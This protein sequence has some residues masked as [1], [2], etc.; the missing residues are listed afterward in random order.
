VVGTRSQLSR[1]RQ[2]VA[3]SPQI[4]QGAQW[5][6][7]PK[8]IAHCQFW[9][10]R[11]PAQCSSG[12]HTEERRFTGTSDSVEPRSGPRPDRGEPGARI[13]MYVISLRTRPARAGVQDG[14]NRPSLCP[15]RK[16]HR[17]AQIHAH[18]QDRRL[19]QGAS[20]QGLARQGI[21][22][23]DRP[24]R[25]GLASNGTS[26]PLAV[27]PHSQWPRGPPSYAPR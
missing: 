10:F 8:L 1:I 12:R 17:T 21:W 14:S 22:R 19:H 27:C 13:T 6:S 26:A 15:R 25:G 16:Q 23:W 18:H 24:R 4:S 9:R 2:P 7:G 3:G 11:P 5:F 20:P